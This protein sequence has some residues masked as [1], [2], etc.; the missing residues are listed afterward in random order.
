MREMIL[1]VC[2]GVQHVRHYRL[3]LASG[4]ATAGT[5]L[6]QRRECD[7]CTE[8]SRLSAFTAP[9]TTHFLDAFPSLMRPGSIWVF[10]PQ[11]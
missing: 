6:E 7:T 9:D 8:T 2:L 1:Y 4:K 5:Y 10:R 11:V 3:V